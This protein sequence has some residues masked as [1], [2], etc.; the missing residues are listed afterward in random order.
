M[1]VAAVLREAWCAVCVFQVNDVLCVFQVNGHQMMDEP[2]EEESYTHCV[3]ICLSLNHFMIPLTGEQAFLMPILVINVYNLQVF[4]SIGSKHSSE[5]KCKRMHRELSSCTVTISSQCANTQ[6]SV[7]SRGGSITLFQNQNQNRS[8]NKKSWVSADID[9]IP[10]KFFLIRV[11]F[12]YLN[13]CWTTHNLLNIDNFIVKK[14]SKW[15]HI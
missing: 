6:F 2:M 8:D 9:P 13:V 7:T 11:E 12:L 3:S 15:M 14:N 10:G 4:D 1:C 5:F